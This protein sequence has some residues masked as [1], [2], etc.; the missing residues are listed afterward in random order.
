MLFSVFYLGE[1]MYMYFEQSKT[2]LTLVCKTYH[3]YPGTPH[4]DKSSLPDEV[5]DLGVQARVVV[6]NPFILLGLS[7]KKKR[8]ARSNFLYSSN[9]KKTFFINPLP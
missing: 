6:L 3:F 9:R 5:L 4:R 2:F 1:T 8:S 7:P